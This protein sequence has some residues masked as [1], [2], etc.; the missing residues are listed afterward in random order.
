MK[1]THFLSLERENWPGNILKSI[2]WANHIKNT[3]LHLHQNYYH[4]E[5]KIQ[6]DLL[7]WGNY[8]A[9]GD[10]TI[11]IL[12]VQNSL[13]YEEKSVRPC[14]EPDGLPGQFQS[15]SMGDDFV[16]FECPS[17][18][19]YRIEVSNGDIFPA[20]ILETFVCLD[21]RP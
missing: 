18:G 3:Q 11:R 2:I 7:E 6:F 13:V 21:H 4:T 19:Y 8:S 16:E 5:D 12:D 14:Y 10:L 20:D 15:F 9:C 1:N 17:P